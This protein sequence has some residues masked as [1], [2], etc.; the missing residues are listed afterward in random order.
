MADANYKIDVPKQEFT[1]VLDTPELMRLKEQKKFQSEVS[2]RTRPKDMFKGVNESVEL[3]SQLK[4]QNAASDANY[5]DSIDRRPAFA[6]MGLTPIMEHNKEVSKLVSNANYK[7]VDHTGLNFETA[8]MRKAREANDLASKVKY[9]Q[10]NSK[11]TFTNESMHEKHLREQRNIQ[12]NR[13]HRQVR[14]T[15][16]GSP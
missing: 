5:K 15:R 6:K 7:Q 13:Y 4:A 8:E 3:S 14:Y 12:S 11:F 16:Y 10:D 1:V 9:K 2:Y